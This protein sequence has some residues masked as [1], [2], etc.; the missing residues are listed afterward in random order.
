MA[1]GRACAWLPDRPPL[2]SSSLGQFFFCSCPLFCAF[3][4]VTTEAAFFWTALCFFPIA[5][6]PAQRFAMPGAP[7]SLFSPDLKATRDGSREKCQTRG[8]PCARGLCSRLASCA[9]HFPCGRAK[10]RRT[11]QFAFFCAN[12]NKARRFFCM[13]ILLLPFFFPVGRCDGPPQISVR[14]HFCWAS[15]VR[16]SFARHSKIVPFS[17]CIRCRRQKV[18]ALPQT[19]II[20][21]PSARMTTKQGVCVFCVDVVA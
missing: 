19:K 21:S 8:L 1:A 11:C 5:P 17:H 9:T 16:R 7:F 20:P 13:E 4:S 18:F 2:L 10:A 3:F 12:T 6:C 14:D 15:P